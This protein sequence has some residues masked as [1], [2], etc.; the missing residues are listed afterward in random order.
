MPTI[1]PLLIP[2]PTELAGPHVCLRPYRREDAADVWEAVEES[3]AQLEPWMPWVYD[4]QEPDDV[5]DEMVRAEAR[6]LLREDLA[7]GIFERASG[8]YLG[9][10]GLHRINW[11]LRTF[12]VGYWLRRTAEGH[13]FA[14]EAV[15]ILTRLAFDALDANRV[16]IRVDTRND[17]SRRVAERLEFALEGT[18]RRAA[19]DVNGRPTSIHVFAL[20]PEEYW[21]LPW[22]EQ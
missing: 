10:S 15:Q 17:R 14:T 19:A 4:Y 5:R 12:E 1:S 2:L 11:P 20:I 18:L 22:A 21:R 8:R 9:G 16:E 13:G 6:W 3:R 7:V